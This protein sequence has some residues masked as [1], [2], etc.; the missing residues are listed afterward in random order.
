MDNTLLV[1]VDGTSAARAQKLGKAVYD[2]AQG[3]DKLKAEAAV[4]YGL[5]AMENGE[6]PQ[7]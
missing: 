4:R 2:A 7:I 3:D 6:E 1:T 5:A